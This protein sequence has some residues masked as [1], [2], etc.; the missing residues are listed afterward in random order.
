MRSATAA[1]LAV[2]RADASTAIG[3]G[4][5]RRCLAIATALRHDGWKCR[6]AVGEESL[7]VVPELTVGEFEVR[8][9]APDVAGAAEAVA[10]SAPDGCHLL[11]VDHYRLGR[12]F[13]SSARRFASRVVAIDDLAD[14]AHD[15]DVLVDATPG[16]SAADYRS[17]VADGTALLLGPA[18]APLRPAFAAARIIRGTHSRD[19]SRLLVNFG[20]TDPDNVTG[21]VLAALSN[22]QLPENLT[23]DIVLGRGAQHAS[24]VTAQV[25]AMPARFRLH[26]DAPEMASLMAGADVA[27]GAGGVSALERCC[28]GLSSVVIAIAENQRLVAVSLAEKG[29]ALLA[30]D[31]DDAARRAVA[32]L[33][34]RPAQRAMSDAAMSLCD[35]RGAARIAAWI[36]PARAKDGRPVRL[37]PATANDEAAILAWQKQPEARRFAR[38]ARM[39]TADEHRAWFASKHTDP[40]CLLNIVLHDGAPVGTVRLDRHADGGWEIS[41]VV[42]AARHDAGIGGAALALARRLVPE[43]RL[44][45]EILPGNDASQALFARAGYVQ[46]GPWYVNQPN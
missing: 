11:V 36:D 13:E 43:A 27:I 5:V 38:N 20:G 25:A 22:Q 28:V 10:R 34:D 17:Q 33:G 29:A 23:V 41:I 6:F 39:P 9:L 8:T 15:C 16:R 12:A 21:A 4:H 46:D 44:L 30:R 24:S 32:L 2:F 14:R 45:A 19:A 7:L 35:G 40:D 42:D 31:A 18:Y 1:K 3:S 37:R 26:L